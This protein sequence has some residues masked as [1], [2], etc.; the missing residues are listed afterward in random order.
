MSHTLICSP[1]SPFVRKAMVLRLE[2]GLQDRVALQPVTT[3]ALNTAAD[4]RAANP[5]GKIPALLRDGDSTL[6]DS[7]VIC[8]YLDELAGSNL[9]PAD[10]LYDVLSLE[11]LADG[12]MESAVSMVYEALLRPETERSPAWV[13][14]QWG[15][16]S[17]ALAA[18][19]RGN[20][21]A[22]QGDLNMGQIA[23]ACAL[24][25]LDFRHPDRNWQADCPTLAAFQKTFAARASMAET[26]P[27]A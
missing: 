17:H 24:D 10:Q 2:A 18:L 1:T 26:Y 14:A 3:N 23:V 8:R 22:L 13:E 4:A 27:A 21:A 20:F 12:M 15:K 5:L 25:Y 7:R 16:V 19:E 11:A 9:Y 6:I